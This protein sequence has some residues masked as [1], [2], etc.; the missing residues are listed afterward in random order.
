MQ[1]EKGAMAFVGMS[2]PEEVVPSS[3][4]VKDGIDMEE[5]K[6]ENENNEEK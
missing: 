6:K 2:F 3:S 1:D 5:A 4:Y